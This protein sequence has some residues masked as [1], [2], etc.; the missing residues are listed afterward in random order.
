MTAATVTVP[1]IAARLGL[2]AVAS[3]AV[4]AVI[5]L[6][7]G[8]LDTGGIGVG[9]SPLEYL[10]FTVLG[11]LLGTAGYLLVSRYAPKALRVVVPAVLVLT[12]IPDLLQLNAGATGANV[13]GLMLMHAVVAVSVVTALRGWAHR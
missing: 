3:M 12:W 13:A 4:N 2:A 1:T 9:L 10:P 5:A 8:A 11:V 6:V 7:A